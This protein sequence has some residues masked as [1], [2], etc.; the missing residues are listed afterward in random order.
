MWPLWGANK[1]PGRSQGVPGICCHCQPPE[2]SPRPGHLLHH[3]DMLGGGE[4]QECVLSP[5]GNE[6]PK[7]ALVT[8]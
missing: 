1:M 8:C 3:K 6:H 5:H 7:Y 4:K 2:A